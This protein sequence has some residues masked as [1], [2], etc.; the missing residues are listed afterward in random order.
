[1]CWSTCCWIVTTKT[2]H[3]WCSRGISWKWFPTVST[4]ATAVIDTACAIGTDTTCNATRSAAL[5]LHE[6][7]SWPTR[8]LNGHIT[9]LIPNLRGLL[10]IPPKTDR[11]FTFRDIGHL[12]FVHDAEIEIVSAKLFI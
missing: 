7:F 1:M 6:G 3:G 2:G 10:R 4:S 5:S 8:L 9:T 11:V 12:N